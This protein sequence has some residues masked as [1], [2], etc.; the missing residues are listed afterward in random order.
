MST[1]GLAICVRC[2]KRTTWVEAR[3]RVFNENA[4]GY[5]GGQL[6]SVEHHRHDMKEIARLKALYPQKI[7]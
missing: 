2:E 4:C 7:R 1:A 5:C 3:Q 6:V